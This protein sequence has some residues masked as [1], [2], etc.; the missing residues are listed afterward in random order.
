MAIN[1]DPFTDVIYI[2][3]ADLS[4]LNPSPEIRQLDLNDFHL[5]LRDWED[6]DE[7]IARPKT[8]NHATEVTLAGLT[9]ARTIE[10]LSPYTVE[11]EDG[12]YIVNCTG[13][14]HNISDTKVA[15]QV[16]LIVNNSAG[17]IVKTIGS[18]LSTEEH[19]QLM[20]VPLDPAGDVWADDNALS[21]L[22]DLAFLK[23]IEGGKWQISGSE[24]IFYDDDN[25]TEIARFAITYDDNQNPIER[26]RI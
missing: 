26:T 16:S 13:A 20:A 2:P 19:D 5:W 17:L 11:F 24:M 7:G 14:N 22:S 10:I 12:Q 1:V 3:K 15:N 25:T 9:Y 21:V 18:G 4:L 6:S 8:H 23:A